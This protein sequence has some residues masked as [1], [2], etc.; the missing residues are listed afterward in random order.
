[1]SHPR[2]HSKHFFHTWLIKACGRAPRCFRIR[3][4]RACCQT[5]RIWNFVSKEEECLE[6]TSN[7]WK[8]KL[9]LPRP[10]RIL[11]WRRVTP[12]GQLLLHSQDGMEVPQ[13]ERHGRSSASS[14]K[15]PPATLRIL[16][17]QF[18]KRKRYNCLRIS[19]Q[20]PAHIPRAHGIH[21]M[22]KAAWDFLRAR[23]NWPIWS[24]RLC[25]QKYN[26]LKHESALIPSN[27]LHLPFRVCLTRIL[28]RSISR[29]LQI[30]K[31]IWKLLSC[32]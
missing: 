17:R 26:G 2:T 14:D 1:M 27:N 30:S 32:Q 21:R 31:L 6:I 15:P 4:W 22:T 24:S 3:L 13:P 16:S 28:N 29:S 23:N 25:A 11:C 19:L 12:Y 20:R 5:E 7:K 10:G 8:G 18:S 9:I